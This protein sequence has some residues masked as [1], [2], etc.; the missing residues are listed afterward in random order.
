MRGCR[1]EGLEEWAIPASPVAGRAAVGDEFFPA[2]PDVVTEAASAES[3]GDGEFCLRKL[4]WLCV[5]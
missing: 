3:F 2:E 4:L 5:I 1:D